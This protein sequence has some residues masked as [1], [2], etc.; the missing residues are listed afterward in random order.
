MLRV[1]SQALIFFLHIEQAL[2]SDKDQSEGTYTNASPP[3]TQS[4]I[5][6]EDGHDGAVNQNA[7]ESANHIPHAAS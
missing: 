5:K 2:N 1:Y 3:R 4:A 7:E 6:L